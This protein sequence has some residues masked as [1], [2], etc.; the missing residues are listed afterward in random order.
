MV[1]WFV[2]DG[3]QAGSRKITEKEGFK[4][5][6]QKVGDLQDPDYTIL[7]VFEGGEM[8]SGATY[9]GDGGGLNKVSESYTDSEFEYQNSV[10]LLEGRKVRPVGGQETSEFYQSEELEGLLD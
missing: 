4:V 2:K 9:E 3:E 7:S 5:H 6:E 8:V 10:S 1:N